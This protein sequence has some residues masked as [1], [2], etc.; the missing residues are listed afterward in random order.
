M[1]KMWLFLL[2]VI[3]YSVR[4]EDGDK[5]W[6]CDA[7]SACEKL[8]RPLVEFRTS[9]KDHDELLKFCKYVAKQG[10][11]IDSDGGGEYILRHQGGSNKS[12]GDYRSSNHLTLCDDAQPE[13]QKTSEVKAIAS[14]AKADVTKLTWSNNIV[15][16]S[17][18]AISDDKVGN[19]FSE[20]VIQPA[21]PWEEK[22]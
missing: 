6:Y 16:E 15:V 14:L 10:G 11:Y 12:E 9:L 5:R 22:N 13:W 19:N 7:S 20:S 8:H 2:C 3:A 21:P 4:A 18:Y 1:H 17:G